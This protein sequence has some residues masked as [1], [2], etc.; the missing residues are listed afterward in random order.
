MKKKSRLFWTMIRVF[1]FIAIGAMN[2]ALIRVEDIGTWK[3]HIGYAFLLFAIMDLIWLSILL[4][5]DKT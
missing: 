5:T 1:G 4:K 2:T 3:N